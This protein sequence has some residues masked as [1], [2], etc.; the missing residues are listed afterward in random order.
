MSDALE[1]R[2]VWDDAEFTWVTFTSS[3][4]NSLYNWEIKHAKE[5]RVTEAADKHHISC[6]FCRELLT[7]C[8]QFRH[9]GPATVHAGVCWVAIIFHT[10]AC[11]IT[12][13]KENKNFSV[14]VCVCALGLLNNLFC[15]N[16]R[17]LCYSSCE[18]W[19]TIRGQVCVSVCVHHHLDKASRHSLSGWAW[20]LQHTG[21]MTRLENSLYEGQNWQS[22]GSVAQTTWSMDQ[23]MHNY[24]RTEKCK[25]PNYCK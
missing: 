19:I 24:L 25:Q 13:D 14:C 2:E 21:H 8:A 23:W 9:F 11:I 10:H 17:S 22:I 18:D 1:K 16:Q 3:F 4:S 5:K 20:S 6:W 15:T 7:T 12:W